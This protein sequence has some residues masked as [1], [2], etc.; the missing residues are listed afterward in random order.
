MQVTGTAT[1]MA[2]M[3]SLD[4]L[5][6]CV[7]DGTGDNGVWVCIALVGSAMRNQVVGEV[8]HPQDVRLDASLSAVW[9]TNVTH[10]DETP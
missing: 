8:P 1:L 3:A 4:N 6:D 2:M 9:R 10:T 5:P 7:A